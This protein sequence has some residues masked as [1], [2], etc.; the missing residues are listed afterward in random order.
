MNLNFIK[1]NDHLKKRIAF[2][3]SFDS[4]VLKV[5]FLE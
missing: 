5:T 1:L 2:Y 3:D 4:K